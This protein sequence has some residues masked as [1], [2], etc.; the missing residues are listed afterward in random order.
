MNIMLVLVTQRTRE[1]GVRLAVGATEWDVQLQFLSEAVALSLLG[2]VLGVLGGLLSS[3]V[4]EQLFDF[5]TQLTPEV[6]AI[7]GLFAVSVGILFGY[8][9]ARKASQLDPIQGLRYRVRIIATR[10]LS[11]PRMPLLLLNSAVVVL[12]F[13]LRT[14][15]LD[16]PIRRFT[17]IM[18]VSGCSCG[19]RRDTKPRRT[20]YG[21]PRPSPSD[22]TRS[23]TSAR[24]EERVV[25]LAADGSCSSVWSARRRGLQGVD[26]AGR[27]CT[28]PLARGGRRKKLWLGQPLT[29]ESAREAAA[30]AV[31]G[32][33]PLSGNGYEAPMFEAAGATND[34]RARTGGVMLAPDSPALS[35]DHAALADHNKLG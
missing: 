20:A 25:R 30:A 14:V 13:A 35:I 11:I 8:Y 29:E 19:A 5:P 32:A 3:A 2:G 15:W 10:P 24:W 16:R 12:R 1:I 27:R 34:S 21:N 31:Q 33:T 17:P 22:A 4:V 28:G 6:F 9:P 18:G 23:V 26:R 7:A